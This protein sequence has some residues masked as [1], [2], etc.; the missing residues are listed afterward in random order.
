MNKKLSAIAAAIIIIVLALVLARNFRSSTQDNPGVK[1]GVITDLTSSAAGTYGIPLKK[2]VD[3]G[4]SEI[5]GNGQAYRA[6]Y[7]DYRLDAKLALPAYEALKLQGVRFFIVDG[8]AAISVLSSEAK[9]DGNMILNPSS[10]VPSYKDGSPLTCRV[11]MTVDT[12]APAYAD[13]VVNKLHKKNI[14]LLIPNIEAGVALRD[15]VTKQIT[16]LGGT[17][18][19]D[20]MYLKDTVDF[21]TQIA[22]IKAVKGLDALIVV[23]YFTSAQTMFSQIK[24]SG[25]DTQLVTDDWT[26]ENQAFNEKDLINGAYS[27]GYAFSGDDPQTDREK[28]F[29]ASFQKRYSTDPGLES[30]LGY[31]LVHILDKAITSSHSTEP[32]TVANYIVSNVQNYAGLSGTL[33]FNSDCEVSRTAQFRQVVDGKVTDMK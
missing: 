15:E 12:Y 21:R 3:F 10:F 4:L 2:G 20:E 26:A 24:E 25:L 17:I 1:I 14:A 6:I 8:S 23:N 32:I 31:D 27:V 11:A 18:V 16:K 5:N 30:I 29:Y 19:Y 22:K 28:A 7:E 9:K 33:S 13:F